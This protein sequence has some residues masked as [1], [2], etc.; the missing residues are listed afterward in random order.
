MVAVS[1]NSTYTNRDLYTKFTDEVIYDILGGLSLS[2]TFAVNIEDANDAGAR[3]VSFLAYDTSLPGTSF[4]TTEVYGDIQ[5]ITQT[6]ANRRTFSP[7]DISFYIKSNYQ[8]INYFDNWINTISPLLPPGSELQPTSYFKF[9]YPS[10]YKK[11]IKIIKYEKNIRPKSERLKKVG[12]INDP[13]TITYVLINA[14]P[15]NI[16]AIPVSYDQSSVLR[17][18]VTFNYD[19]YQLLQNAGVTYKPQ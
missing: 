9:N 2:S 13:N 1:P 19:R 8:T 10:S 11:T 18:T 14:Y 16:S 5:G 15:T 17:M 4:Q 3:P 12:G 7:V 6:F